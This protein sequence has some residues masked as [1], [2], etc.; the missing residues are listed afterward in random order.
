MSDSLQ[1]LVARPGKGY[2]S[3]RR[4]RGAVGQD[5]RGSRARRRIE[6]YIIEQEGSAYPP[7]ETV[8]RCLANY[9]KMRTS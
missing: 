4:R 9:K 5:I 8:Q 1:G 3:L 6:H 2:G 7:L